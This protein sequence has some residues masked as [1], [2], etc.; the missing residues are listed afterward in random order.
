M[1]MIGFGG[2]NIFVI[3]LS[4]NISEFLASYLEENSVGIQL[5]NYSSQLKKS[6][7]NFNLCIF[8][9]TI[10]E[11]CD[12]VSDWF[13]RNTKKSPVIVNNGKNIS[14]N[15][16]LPARD[17]IFVFIKSRNN[18]SETLMNVESYPHFTNRAK[19]QYIIC[20]RV[21]HKK[22]LPIT[23]KRI[24][25]MGIFNFVMVY[26]YEGLEVISYNAFNRLKITNLTDE[27]RSSSV[28]FPNKLRDVKGHTF[29]VGMY[30]SYP[31]NKKSDG[32]WDGFE[33]RLLNDTINL[34]NGKV[35]IVDLPRKENNDFKIDHV[36]N[37]DFTFIRKF[38]SQTEEGFDFIS[39]FQMDDLVGLVPKN[40]KS[41]VSSI[42]HMF[43]LTTVFT[44]VMIL[45]IVAFIARA[46][47]A[48]SISE[49]ILAL[50]YILCGGSVSFPKRMPGSSKILFS[51]FS[52]FALLLA[53]IFQTRFTI[54]L[55]AWRYKKNIN[56]IKD[57]HESD[58]TIAVSSYHEKYIPE[59]LVEQ[60]VFMDI[61]LVSKSIFNDSCKNTAFIMTKR[62]SL[63]VKREFHYQQKTFPFREMKSPIVPGLSAI[64][65][66]MNSPYIDHLRRFISKSS[67]LVSSKY[68]FARRKQELEENT[69][70]HHPVHLDRSSRGNIIINADGPAGP[71]LGTLCLHWHGP[72]QRSI[73][74]TRPMLYNSFVRNR[75]W[76]PGCEGLL[77]KPPGPAGYSTAEL[78]PQEVYFPVA[79]KDS[80]VAM[81][82]R[83][84]IG[85][86]SVTR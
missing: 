18:L 21:D 3:I 4:L 6:D 59:M 32:R 16:H 40:H 30:P 31:M 58:L 20:S 76:P 52:V 36:K 34:M 13:I 54:N 51:S 66:P 70:T 57:L 82:V 5:K 1:N 17:C 50:W 37:C 62:L 86:R 19:I 85:T 7:F 22:W 23:L 9:N 49:A 47:N 71:K 69:K 48:F 63:S 35:N 27:N 8:Y 24:W 74:Q 26:V 11:E 81:Y 72:Q 60:C 2:T 61:S 43:A 38:L 41:S 53:V 83:D 77:E 79:W 33:V 46:G 29:N 67:S 45:L 68:I 84:D 64:W 56:N 75:R 44:L 65:F 42:E 78:G 12:E 55:V 14:N 39:L 80:E 28:L 25:K 10:T 15:N 73:G